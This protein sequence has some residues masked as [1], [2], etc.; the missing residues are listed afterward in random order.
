MDEL[1]PYSYG[2][3]LLDRET[4]KPVKP[5]VEHRSHPISG[6]SLSPDGKRL[7]VRLQLPS[8]MDG[9]HGGWNSDAEFFEVQ[10]WDATTWQRDWV[11]IVTP[12]DYWK[13]IGGAAK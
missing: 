5:L 1:K 11:K 12:P 2:V 9:D 13:Q 4:G 6:L 3:W 10:Q 8:R 7:R